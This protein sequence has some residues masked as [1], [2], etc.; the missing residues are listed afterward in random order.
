MNRALTT[1]MIT[2]WDASA[3]DDAQNEPSMLT[4]MH[5]AKMPKPP[6]PMEPNASRNG[7]GAAGRDAWSAEAKARVSDQAR[8]SS[9]PLTSGNAETSTIDAPCGAAMAAIDSNAATNADAGAH[10]STASCGKRAYSW[11]HIT[12]MSALPAPVSTADT[13]NKNGVAAK[14]YACRNSIGVVTVTAKGAATTSA[15]QFVG[16]P[17]RRSAATMTTSDTTAEP[18][19]S[20]LNARRRAAPPP[21]AS[22]TMDNPSMDPE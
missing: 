22:T 1:K 3:E 11:P 13:A 6:R 21:I 4:N 8:Q 12:H 19:G 7:S 15:R 20:T 5:A 17:S 2:A 14:P 10:D 16:G 9:A 18:T